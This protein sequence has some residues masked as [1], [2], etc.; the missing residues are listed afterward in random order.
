MARLP[1]ELLD[2]ISRGTTL[3]VPSRQR[4]RAVRLE[5]ARAALASSRAAFRTADVLSVEAFL[6]RE[7]A[8][9]ATTTRILTPAEEFW[10]WREAA[11]ASLQEHAAESGLLTRDATGEALRRTEQLAFDYRIDPGLLTSVPGAE[12]ALWRATVRRV[13]ELWRKL[14]AAPA[15]RIV[16]RAVD[17]G[18]RERS[19]RVVFAGFDVITP[20]LREYIAKQ[21]VADR[22]MRIHEIPQRVVP[23]RIVRAADATEELDAIAKWC[24]D[25][26]SAGPASKLLIVAPGP[27]V[28]R[29]RLAFLVRQA[30]RPAT[31]LSMTGAPSDP[32][33]V[34]I[35]GGEPLASA[36]IVE[37]ALSTLAWLAFGLDHEEF[38]RWLHSPYVGE[39]DPIACTGLDEGLR[40]RLPLQVDV[41]AACA[42]L[43]LLPDAMSQPAR[44][45]RDS[46][47]AA[48]AVLVNAAPGRAA[49]GTPREWS[50][51]FTHALAALGWPS[52]RAL[53]S[54]EQ[55]SHIRFVELLGELGELRSLAPALDLREALALLRAYAMRVAFGPASQDAAVT[56]T[57]S[58]ADPIVI[59]DGIWVAGLHANNWPAAAQADPFLP[60]GAQRAASVPRA[61]GELQT[62]IARTN[63][64]AWQAAA[65]ELVLSSPAQIDDLDQEESPL[66]REVEAR[67]QGPAPTRVWLPVRARRAVALEVLDAEHGLPWAQEQ[68]LPNG[69]RSLELQNLCAFRAY[70]ELRL[71]AD[72]R[73]PRTPGIEPDQRGR[74]LHRA[75]QL[76]WIEV[77]D[78]QALA[79]LSAEEV[80]ALARRC[81]QSAFAPVPRGMKSAH[82]T[83]ATTDREMRRCARLV[84]GLAEL[85]R[86]RAAFRVV[87]TESPRSLVL[88]GAR[89]EMR[90]DRIDWIEGARAGAGGMA[91]IDYKSRKP[92]RTDWYGERP[93]HPQLLAYATALGDDVI[94]VAIASISGSETKFNGI[95]AAG[96][97]IPQVAAVKAAPDG[98]DGPAWQSRARAF[99]ACVT[100]LAADFAAGS[101]AL[102]PRPDACAICHLGALC[103]L[104]EWQGLAEEDAEDEDAARDS[105]GRDD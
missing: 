9:A 28:L 26:L 3:V 88:G 94:A 59:Y 39:R 89:L 92:A 61:S 4:A 49:S 6:A 78:S 104:A 44:A 65:D 99:E 11:A 55:Q 77:A 87:A 47:M 15:A 68:A 29:Q 62:A 80:R 101:A 82:A 105:G 100:G 97:L 51:R 7:A 27:Q 16:A 10:I 22:E 35:E 69:T 74:W 52:G 60:I 30:L 40:E 84:A 41:D 50:E 64:R 75:L 67:R 19:K 32:D 38:S 12:S 23:A 8:H 43:E 103:R 70:A 81:A 57:A 66:L 91:V 13:H 79:A 2:E 76:F 86:S 5:H 71:G 53:S 54:A 36:P 46:M 95:A 96:N 21:R 98:P 48:R 45:L 1:L 17:S 63:L 85:E 20:R 37:A 83:S 93:T 31:S 102:N 34:A 18:A 24:V 56:I 42:A 72:M 73:R 58:T 33:P 90:I 14:D 25:R